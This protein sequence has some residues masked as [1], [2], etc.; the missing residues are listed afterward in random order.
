MIWIVVLIVILVLLA[1]A[2]VA[3]LQPARPAAQPRRQRVGADRRAA[4]AALRPDPEPRRD[5]QGLRGARARDVR[6]RDAR[7]RGRR[8][9]AGPAGAVGGR[10]PARPGARPA[11]RG[12]RG[13]PGAAGRRELPAAADGARRDREPDRRLAPGLQRHRAD[14]QQRDPDG[15]GRGHR[16]PVRVRE[17]GVLRGRGRCRSARRR[18]STSR[19]VRRA[20]APQSS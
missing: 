12:R 13:V 18:A 20:R 2:L 5:G 4:E 1:L 6:E 15:P 14:V 9:G 8:R 10:G 3:P 17:A 11:V 16:R 19:R 7:T